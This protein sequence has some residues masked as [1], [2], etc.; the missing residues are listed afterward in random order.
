[1]PLHLKQHNHNLVSRP[2]VKQT[3]LEQQI[4]RLAFESLQLWPTLPT[5]PTTPTHQEKSIETIV[6]LPETIF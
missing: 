1:M 2:K 4:S 6:S 3:A 5:P